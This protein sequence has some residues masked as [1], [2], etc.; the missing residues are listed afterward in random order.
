MLP[1]RR[2]VLQAAA[3][4]ALGVGPLRG[5]LRLRT[6][7]SFRGISPAP[8]RLSSIHCSRKGSAASSV[9]RAPSRT[10]VVGHDEVRRL[11]YLLVT[12]EFSAAAM[13]D[14]YARATGRPG[15]LCI[16]SLTNSLSGL[17]ESLLDSIPV[18]AIVGDVANGCHTPAPFQVHCLDQAAATPT[19]H[20]GNARRR[21]RRRH[22]GRHPPRHAD[23]LQRRTRSRRRR[24]PYN[25]LIEAAR[26]NSPPLA[27]AAVPFDEA[28]Y[29]QAR[30]SAIAVTVSASTPAWVAW[31]M[32]T[33]GVGKLAE[34]L[35]R[36]SPRA[37][38]ARE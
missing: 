27:E 3:A 24:H 9:F 32:R 13:A 25:L 35:R 4:A 8:K 21:T 1:S 17:G 15:V 11:P 14:G 34:T 26:F 7:P 23:R 19:G 37:S 38:P 2:D 6:G 28:A 10:S 16:V 33:P 36:P 31:T 20:Q 18:V 22:P 30:L 5:G 29:N 12:H